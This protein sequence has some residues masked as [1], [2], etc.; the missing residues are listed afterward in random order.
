MIW[1]DKQVVLLLST[2]VKSVALPGSKLLVR[3]KIGGRKK[4]ICTT[5]MYLQYT[6]NMRGVDAADQ[7]RSIYLCLM[8]SH[9]WWYCIFFY[10]LGTMVCNM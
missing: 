4:E 2:Y 10:M 9:K 5:P 7:L 3:R 1:K 8:R 6:I